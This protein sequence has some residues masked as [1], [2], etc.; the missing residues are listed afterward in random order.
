LSNG[1]SGGAGGAGFSGRKFGK[2]KIGKVSSGGDRAGLSGGVENIQTG[3]GQSKPI[4]NFEKNTP[5]SGQRVGWMNR[6]WSALTGSGKS[7]QQGDKVVSKHEGRGSR[8]PKEFL[9]TK[10]K[11]VKDLKPGEV[12]YNHDKNVILISGNEGLD[13]RKL[14]K[15]IIKLARSSKRFRDTTGIGIP[16]REKQRA[17]EGM[18]RHQNIA[19]SRANKKLLSSS[20]QRS[21]AKSSPRKVVLGDLVNKKYQ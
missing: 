20:T 13:K 10:I 7:G 1:S 2:N 18:F 12:R 9:E 4:S 17:F 15:Q 16:T 3:V 19:I 21:R 6:G 8:L 14:P 5:W 11:V